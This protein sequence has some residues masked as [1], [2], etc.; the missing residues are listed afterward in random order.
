MA[1]DPAG[2]LLA[3][4][5]PDDRLALW[6]LDEPRALGWRLRDAATGFTAAALSPDSRL[7]AWGSADAVNLLD[8]AAGRR[9]PP[10]AVPDKTVT[11]VAFSPDSRLL[12]FAD[13]EMPSLS[14][15]IHVVSTA[16]HPRRMRRVRSSSW[17]TCR[18]GVPDREPGSQRSRVE[19]VRERRAVPPQL[20]AVPGKI[21]LLFREV[22]ESA[23]VFRLI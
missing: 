12:A 4:A 23:P 11:A 18:P 1:F 8:L 19:P 20:R 5:L 2:R 22:K 7:L 21:Q 15:R 10:I 17:W 14:A 9:L 6:H 13:M 3:T 16:T